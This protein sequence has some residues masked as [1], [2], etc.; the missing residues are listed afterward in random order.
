MLSCK[1]FRKRLPA[2]LTQS[3]TEQEQISL[4]QHIKNCSTC[5]KLV[6]DYKILGQK[7]ILDTDV[8]LQ[9]ADWQKKEEVLLRKIHANVAL[10]HVNIL[11]KAFLWFSTLP[12][13]F[14]IR[15]RYSFALGIII[16]ALIVVILPSFRNH[17]HDLTPDIAI[18]ICDDPSAWSSA[19]F[20]D[21]SSED[22][23]G[24][25]IFDKNET[26]NKEI[27]KIIL[28]ELYKN[29]DSTINDISDEED[30]IN[31]LWIMVDKLDKKGKKMLEKEL[32]LPA[33]LN[34]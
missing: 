29:E 10:N 33:G 31:Q 2:L 32:K 23:S 6:E 20:Y 1:Q 28:S 26:D 25:N 16:A 5:R 17:S 30:G 7:L 12:A 15:A 27:E 13:S 21:F 4:E 22:T 18:K 8:E 11:K 34:A 3:T 19:I 14:T 24:S 9:E